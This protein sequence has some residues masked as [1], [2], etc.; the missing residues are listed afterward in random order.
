MR[1]E[2]TPIDGTGEAAGYTFYFQI[3]N[4]GVRQGC[5]VEVYA[6]DPKE[7]SILFREN[8]SVIES[9]ARAGINRGEGV[10]SL[11]LPSI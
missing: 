10:L 9:M 6:S 5:R 2:R 4:A 7:A 8:W 11:V 1:Q 3:A